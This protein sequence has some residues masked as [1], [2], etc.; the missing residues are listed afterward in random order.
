MLIFSL[1][2]CLKQSQIIDK[3]INLLDKNTSAQAYPLKVLSVPF[4]IFNLTLV[5]SLALTWFSCETKEEHAERLAKQYCGSCH[6][7]PEPNLL[8][9]NIWKN[10]VLP[11]MAFRMGQTDL[12]DG[13]KYTSIDDLL[14]AAGT[15]PSEPMVTEAEWNLIV[16]YFVEKSPD[17]LN[18]ESKRTF[19]ELTLFNPYEIKNAEGSTAIITMVKVDTLAHKIFTG[20]RTGRLIQYNDQL[21]PEYSLQLSSPPSDL[22]FRI[23]Q[24]P[25]IS[26]MGIMDPN[27]Q[28]K[29]SIAELDLLANAN[30]TGMLIDSIQRPVNI[31]E[32]DL[33]K[34]GL[35]DLVTCA[36]GN[37]TGALLVYENKGDSKYVTHPISNL[38]GSRKSVVKDFNNDGLVDIMALFTQGD[39]QIILF[40][41]LGNF[42]FKQNILLRFPPVY[43]S[44]YF[45]LADFNQDGLLD[46]LYTNGDNSDY[47]QILK[48]YH[49]MR[50]FLQNE[51][52]SF[53]ES[54]FYPLH[55]ASKAIANDFDLDGDLDIAC[56]SFFPDF[57]NTAEES[58]V[59]LENNNNTYVAHTLPGP[60]AGRWIVMEVADMEG[61]GD[62]DILLGALDFNT[63]VPKVLTNL[64]QINSTAVLVLKNSAH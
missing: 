40:T 6:V 20:S 45:D 55:G 39:E 7:F 31:E 38:P 29:G 32:A 44:S 22:I 4:R 37:Y 53:R 15:R 14:I 43:G 49:G 10:E 3:Y 25:I 61:D 11:Y 13:I 57:E 52:G 12:M 36:F 27:D 42:K 8:P 28:S 17:T 60:P 58:F 1:I 56:I 26:L 59:Y 62:K 18:Q 46:I 64:W 16:D 30:K 24:K 2:V 50:I 47:S 21:N 54:W 34:D 5:A 9:K 51:E 33:N 41:N 19:A 35:P 48:P 63:K 23:N